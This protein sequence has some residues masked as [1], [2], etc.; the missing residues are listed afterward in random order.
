MEL[1]LLDLYYVF[2]D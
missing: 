1:F 2:L